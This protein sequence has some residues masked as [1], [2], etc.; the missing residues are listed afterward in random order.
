[1]SF[2]VYVIQSEEGLRYTGHAPDLV[3][4]LSEHNAGTTHSTKHGTNWKIIHTEEF[5]SRGEA[6]KRE[7]FLKTGAG[8]D[9]L[10]T[11]VGVE[12]AAAE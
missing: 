9:F 1:M 12:S 8:R 2:F 3:R 11:I 7:K 4:R 6:M 10:K 5:M